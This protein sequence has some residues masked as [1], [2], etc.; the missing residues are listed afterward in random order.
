MPVQCIQQ[1][2]TLT[3]R[4][5]GEVDHH[6]AKEMMALLVEEIDAALPERLVLELSQ[7][8]FM[9]SSGIA[10]LLNLWRRMGQLEGAMTIRRTPPPSP[11]GCC[12]RRAW[13]G[14][15]ILRKIP[16]PA[17]RG[18]SEKEHIGAAWGPPG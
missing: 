9:G 17:G 1:G 2:R 11:C 12:G 15:C 10:V 13:T 3:A 14:C 16:R 18:R 4:L 7:V 6:A 5:S 8:S